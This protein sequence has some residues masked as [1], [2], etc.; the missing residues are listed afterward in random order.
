LGLKYFSDLFLRYLNI[1]DGGYLYQAV[2]NETTI[3]FENTDMEMEFKTS[4]TIKKHL[5]Q[6]K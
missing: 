2:E 5:K 6:R 3:S 4:D 1:L